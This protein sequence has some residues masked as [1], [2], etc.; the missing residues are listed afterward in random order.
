MFP[1]KYFDKFS[2][3]GGCSEGLDA[4]RFFLRACV[5]PDDGVCSDW[6]EVEQRLRQGCVLSPLLFNIFFAAVLTVVLQRFSEE[7]AILAELVH[8]K[9]LPTSMG[10]ESAMDYVR[11][12]VWGILYAN[13]ACIVS[14]SPQG[15]AKMMEVIVEVCRAFALT[16]SV[17]KTETM[18]MPPPRTPDNCANRSGR[19]N[20]Q[21][22]AILHLPRGRRDRSPG[23]V[24]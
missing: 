13:D 17:K 24:R 21:T 5:R 19:T 11:R 20:V 2:P 8:L 18:C 3:E 16:V 12:A 1:P 9:E 23:H 14:R 15:L 10:P 6:F 4:F 22:G 7:P